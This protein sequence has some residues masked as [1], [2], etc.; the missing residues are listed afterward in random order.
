[1][2]LT[3]RDM[4]LQCMQRIESIQHALDLL[5]QIKRLIWDDHRS[6]EID[7]GDI[8]RILIEKELG[9]WRNLCMWGLTVT[10]AERDRIKTA[11]HERF[12]RNGMSVA[13]WWNN[14]VAP[15]SYL[16]ADEEQFREMARK[17]FAPTD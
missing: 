2:N 10:D 7:E 14:G 1:M 17:A 3:N 12:L 16:T 4:V 13:H 8:G 11:V 6:R 5:D 9:E 15:S